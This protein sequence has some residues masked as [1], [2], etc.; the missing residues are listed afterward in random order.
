MAGKNVLAI[1]LVFARQVFPTM[2]LKV[3]HRHFFGNNFV[4]I[5]RATSREAEL[6]CLYGGTPFL[7]DA[8]EGTLL[9]E[10][11]LLLFYKRLSWRVCRVTYCIFLRCR[12][13]IIVRTEILSFRFS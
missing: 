9:P 12:G 3:L 13:Q 5:R 7:L 6:A 2:I 4:C 11:K 10:L 1:N 8:A